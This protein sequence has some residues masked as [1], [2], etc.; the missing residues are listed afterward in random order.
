MEWEGG[1]GGAGGCSCT[2][3]GGTRP[4][5]TCWW[6]LGS[7]SGTDTNA[8]LCAA[9]CFPVSQLRAA[10]LYKTIGSNTYYQ[11]AKTPAGMSPTRADASLLMSCAKDNRT[12]LWDLFSLKP[13]Y[14]LPPGAGAE[15]PA[16]GRFSFF[17]A[18]GGGAWCLACLAGPVVCCVLSSYVHGHGA[19]AS[20][21]RAEGV[22][23]C[24]ARVLE[25]VP[26]QERHNK[27]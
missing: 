16:S 27:P 3:R 9:L 12:L 20:S 15:L 22:H 1:E 6:E 4:H 7:S 23:C 13:V 5:Y 10:F 24:D 26:F 18:W 25:V 8:H 11:T 2:R 21:S 19:T 17:S 14:E